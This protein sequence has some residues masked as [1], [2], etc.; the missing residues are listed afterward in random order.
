LYLLDPNF[1]H[2]CAAATAHFLAGFARICGVRWP[3]IVIVGV[4]YPT[5]DPREVMLCRARDL[6]PTPAGAPAGIA[7]P[8]WTFGEAATFLAALRE[9]VL[10]AAEAHLALQPSMRV[11][12]GHSFGGLFGLYTLFHQPQ[13]FG[14]YLL[15]SPSLWWDERI[16][17]RY[18][19]TFAERGQPLQAL[20]F[21]AV[22]KGEQAPGGGWKNEGFSDQAVAMLRQVDNLRE[23]AQCL[24]AR[25][26]A[27]LQLETAIFDD[28][29]HLT[30]F[31]AAFA[32]GL[33]WLA[34]R[35]G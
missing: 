18:E 10:P 34:E 8:P 15:F 4:G 35:L 32:R 24:A 17:F 30:I 6:T 13:A 21:M 16:V 5:D 25:N 14:A 11:L 7:L 20:L 19:Q 29:Y 2:V 3:G 9:D 33:R 22:G 28:E 31:P 1:N 23:V 26:H 12:A 27:G